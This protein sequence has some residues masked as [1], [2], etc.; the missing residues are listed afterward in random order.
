MKKAFTLIEIIIVITLLSILWT[1]SFV[2]VNSYLLDT[3]NS[4]RK[5]DILSLESA[6][7]L[8]DKEQNFLPDPSDLKIDNWIIKQWV[9]W[10][11]S[12]LN[13]LREIPIDPTTKK[14]YF[15]SITNKNEENNYKSEFQIWT[16]LEWTI[17][18]AMIKWN[19]EAVLYN[20]PSILFVWQNAEKS[21]SVIDERN[22]NL[23]YSFESESEKNTFITTSSYWHPYKTCDEI[24]NSQK[25]IKSWL[26]YSLFI[27]ENNYKSEIC[28]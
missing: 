3:R 10:K 7:K 19:Y 6:L 16:T 18:K 14:P 24:K 20:Y 12:P 15:Y 11:N 9:L 5:I 23:L 2:S 4:K 26:A 21:K 22:E 28:N 1:I 8:F 27:S 25:F 13:T 17:E